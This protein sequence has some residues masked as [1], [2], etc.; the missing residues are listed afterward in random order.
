[1]PVSRQTVNRKTGGKTG[2]SN[3]FSKIM[4]KANID[5]D[6][7]SGKGK[8][9]FSLLSFHS[10]RHSFN[11]HLANEGVDQETWQIMTGHDT[12]AA[13]DDY[14]HLDLPKLRAAVGHTLA[15]AGGIDPSIPG[16]NRRSPIIK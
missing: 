7:V 15:Q 14:T 5:P 6:L 4:K 8:K 3:E 9:R 1:M 11:S 10:L 2:L 12:K 16:V 13:N